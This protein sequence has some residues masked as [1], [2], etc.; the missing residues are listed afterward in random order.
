MGY[1]CVFH[2]RAFDVLFLGCC[3][4]RGWSPWRP[5]TGEGH[6]FGA[7]LTYCSCLTL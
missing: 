7:A 4:L 6:A 3:P 2:M 1:T 5:G